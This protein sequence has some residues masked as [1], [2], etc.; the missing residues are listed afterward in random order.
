MPSFHWGAVT[1]PRLQPCAKKKMT[2]KTGGCQAWDHDFAL[3][4]DVT[5]LGHLKVDVKMFFPSPAFASVKGGQQSLGVAR[6]LAFV[7]VDS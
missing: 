6:G 1:C 3:G 4:I 5:S 7:H 2:M